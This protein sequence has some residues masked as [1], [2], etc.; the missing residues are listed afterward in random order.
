MPSYVR[1]TPEAAV[2][3]LPGWD[4]AEGRAAIRRTFRFTDFAEA[5][6][7]MAH[8]AVLAEK[9]DHH[10]EWFNVYNRVD[11]VLTTHDAASVTDRDVAL[12]QAMDKAAQ[13]SAVAS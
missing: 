1:F 9:Q 7:F 12:A 6:G 11:V 4:V 2:A 8:I 3:L 13:R 5:F 10:P